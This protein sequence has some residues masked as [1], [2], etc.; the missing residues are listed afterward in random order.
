MGSALQGA[1][2]LNQGYNTG[3]GMLVQGANSLNQGYNTG[4]TC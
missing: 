2:A 4:S 1:N 3:A